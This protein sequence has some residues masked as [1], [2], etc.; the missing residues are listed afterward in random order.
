MKS[1]NSDTSSEGAPASPRPD[2]HDH[3][4]HVN[5]RLSGLSREKSESSMNSRAAGHRSLRRGSHVSHTSSGSVVSRR[6]S[7]PPQ[8][9]EDDAES[10]KS[11]GE[12]DEDVCFPLHADTQVEDPEGIDVNTLDR[13]LEGGSASSSDGESDANSC[14]HPVRGAEENAKTSPEN[15]LNTQVMSPGGLRVPFI[16]QG[17]APPPLSL[18]PAADPNEH[19]E[20]S[21]HHTGDDAV[22]GLSEN[23][24]E[25]RFSFF[26]TKRKETVH[27]ANLQSLV[28]PGVSFATLFSKK[29]GVWWLDCLNPTDLE[30]KILSRAFGIH[31]LTAEDIRTEESREKFELFGKYYFVCFHTFGNNP[32]N[33]EWYLEPINFYI[34]VF[35]EGVIS[36]HYTPVSH[37]RN[38]R[39]RIRQLR[40]YV[41]VTSDWV[42]Y[43]IIDDITD[44]FAPIIH[45]VEAETDRIEDDVYQDSNPENMNKVLNN[46]AETRKTTMRLLRLLSGKADVIKG[47]AKR[48]TE[49]WQSR[50]SSDI[51]IYLG[52]IQDH[53]I[54]MYQNLTAYEKILSRSHG[55][56]MSHLQMEFVNASNNMTSVLSKATMIGTILV[57]MNLITGLFGMNVQVPGQ[58]VENLNWWFSILGFMI[59]MILI[60]VFVANWWINRL[61]R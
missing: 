21:V 56:Y 53:I 36:F 58:N 19:P 6:S 29:N 33:Q 47:F 2:L 25:E 41:S 18:P 14:F 5:L 1:E 8:Q 16:P 24:G 23:A 4:T 20:E 51:S 55:N 60:L 48:C 46:L 40:N 12:T 32:N 39:R 28:D 27:A 3:R 37:C 35:L 26:A 31:P 44:S 49:L 43:A 11:I 45:E 50:S 22:K 15:L 17:H 54:T 59:F 42:C 30:I 10:D 61:V 38:V 7:I 13:L 9:D 57:P 52:D 34:I